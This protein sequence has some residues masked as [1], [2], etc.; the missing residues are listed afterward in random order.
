MNPARTAILKQ[1]ET[2]VK[3]LYT[4]NFDKARAIFDKLIQANADDKELVERARIHI[5]LCE[6]KKARKIPAP[7]SVDEH[8]DVAI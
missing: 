3:L 4:Q 1:Y 7:R 8:Y 5:R 6:Q 2:G